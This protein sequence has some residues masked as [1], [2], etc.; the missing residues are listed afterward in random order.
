MECCCSEHST[1]AEYVM[2]KG[3]TACRLTHRTHDIGT[4]SGFAAAQETV[5]RC[6]P[7]HFIATPPH[8]TPGCRQSRQRR[9]WDHVWALAALAWESGSHI[10]IMLPASSACWRWSAEG[11]SYLNDVVH[12]AA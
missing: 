3:G 10:T 2:M 7:R 6:R 5:R 12:K 11:R 4:Q 9:I 8:G 1:L